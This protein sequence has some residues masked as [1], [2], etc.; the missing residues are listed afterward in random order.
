MHIQEHDEYED[1]LAV[2]ISMGCELL[3]NNQDKSDSTNIVTIYLSEEASVLSDVYDVIKDTEAAE[4]AFFQNTL[5]EQAAY[6]IKLQLTSECKKIPL[7]NE[8]IDGLE[9]NLQVR[10]ISRE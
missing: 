5:V 3:F 7:V 10:S 4:F 6:S 2:Q 9:G 8:D 1:D